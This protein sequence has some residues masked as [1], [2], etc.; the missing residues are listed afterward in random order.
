MIAQ[1]GC[2]DTRISQAREGL[3]GKA[4]AEQHTAAPSRLRVLVIDDE[5]GLRRCVAGM[6]RGAGHQVEEASSST[7]G[8]RR[9]QAAPLDVVLTDLRMPGGSGWE[10]VR[11]A[12]DLHPGPPV[13]V[14]TADANAL[15]AEGGAAALAA[16]ILIK[17]FAMDDLLG[18]LAKMEEALR[19][20]QP[21]PAA[22]SSEAAAIQ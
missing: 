12:H 10:V 22:V 3:E 11:A 7:E 20:P 17:P 16:G 5:Y 9:L 13:L 6:I 1:H 19:T 8:V 2:I 15:E 18:R 4:S 21:P 14:M